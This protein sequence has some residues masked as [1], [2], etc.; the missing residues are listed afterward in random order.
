MNE[1]KNDV[2]KSC[3]AQLFLFEYN[4]VLYR[5]VNYPYSLEDPDGNVY[6]AIYIQRNSPVIRDLTLEAPILSIYCEPLDILKELNTIGGEMSLWHYM[7]TIP[8]AV[9]AAGL[10]ISD[11]YNP[12]LYK[13]ED[14]YKPDLVF[15]GEY[16][17]INFEQDSGLFLI[18]FKQTELGRLENFLLKVPIQRFCN[19]ALFDEHCN[20]V[21][22]S[23][24]VSAVLSNI[25]GL[26]LTSPTFGTHPDAYFYLGECVLE[27]AGITQERLIIGH[28]GNEITLQGPLLNVEIGDTVKVYP[29][30][31]KQAETCFNKFGNIL[32]FTGFPYLQEEGA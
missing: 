3:I 11:S 31:D 22:A 2:Y 21:Q 28:T 1:I 13:N 17:N 10:C 32:N 8:E 16:E 25:D 14:F 15:T 7:V 27:K 24:E 9:N 20:L 26:V 29:G 30:C 19:N 12:E 23:Y 18:N 5:Y 4:E 6:E